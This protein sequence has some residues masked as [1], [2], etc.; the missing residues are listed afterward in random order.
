MDG[1]TDMS[2]ERATEVLQ[3]TVDEIAAADTANALRLADELHDYVCSRKPRSRRHALMLRRLAE[4]VFE[5]TL[6]PRFRLVGLEYV[7]KHQTDPTE[8]IH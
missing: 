3:R 6:D 8:R 1:G 7:E 2:E 5:E 4:I